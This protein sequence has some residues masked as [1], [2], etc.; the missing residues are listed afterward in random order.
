MNAAITAF[1][2][3]VVLTSGAAALLFGVRAKE[4][5]ENKS[6]AETFHF[7]FD[8]AL[9][10]AALSSFFAWFYFRRVLPDFGLNVNWMTTSPLVWILPG[11]LALSATMHVRTIREKI[12]KGVRF[13]LYMRLSIV[14]AALMVV[15]FIRGLR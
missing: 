2:L 11:L 8:I 15:E 10:H 9:G 3:G 4:F 14:V 6:R 12:D 5:W 7:T 13:P 1:Y